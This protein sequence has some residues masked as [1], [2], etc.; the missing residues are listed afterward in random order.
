M[1]PAPAQ[2]IRLGGGAE[3]DTPPVRLHPQQWDRVVKALRRGG[4][5]ADN[6]L[7]NNVARQVGL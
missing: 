7:A 4:T 1:R 3:R 2:P 5:M 6:D